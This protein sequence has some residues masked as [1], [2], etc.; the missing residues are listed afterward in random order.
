MHVIIQNFIKQH[1]GLKCIVKVHDRI[2]EETVRN[3]QGLLSQ[4]L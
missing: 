4:K 2:Q 3:E 1:F